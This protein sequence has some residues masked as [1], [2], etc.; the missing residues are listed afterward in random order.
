LQ[1]RQ[2]TETIA[3]HTRIFVK[4]PYANYVIQ[5]ILD[6]KIAEISTIVGQ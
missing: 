2:L 4:N 3:S 6:L 1:K 5:Y